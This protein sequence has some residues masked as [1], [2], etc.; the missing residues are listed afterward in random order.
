MNTIKIGKN[1]TIGDSAMIHCSGAHPTVIGDRVIVN[2]KA[3]IHGCILEEESVVGLGA[4]VMDGAKIEKQGM[5][6]DGGLLSAGKT[7]PTGQC[8]AGVPAVFVRNLSKSEIEEIGILSEDNTELSL[9]HAQ[10]NRKDWD[11]V[12][13]EHF[14]H[15]QETERSPDYFKRLSPEVSLAAC[16]VTLHS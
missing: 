14:N 16:C 15:E 12:E 2:S 8:W 1:V 7:I 3:I 10:E 6:C 9:L 11:T 4:Q 13:M 5:L